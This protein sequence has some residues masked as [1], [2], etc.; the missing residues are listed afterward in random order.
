MATIKRTPRPRSGKVTSDP[1]AWIDALAAAESER[2]GTA[3]PKTPAEARAFLTALLAALD[4]VGAGPIEARV[5]SSA[6]EAWKA[7]HR[8]GVRDLKTR[9]RERARDLLET[10]HKV[11]EDAKGRI[12]TRQQAEAIVLNEERAAPLRGDMVRE[13]PV[14][15]WERALDRLAIG[16]RGRGRPR[17]GDERLSSDEIVL[18]L[19]EGEPDPKRPRAGKSRAKS[20]ADTRSAAARRR[21]NK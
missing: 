20:A 9:T 3:P 2:F 1:T 16:V 11:R 18:R 12:S 6:H 21:A 14:E 4:G 10:S 13:L 19:L 15:R 17:P 5:I 8:Q 7:F